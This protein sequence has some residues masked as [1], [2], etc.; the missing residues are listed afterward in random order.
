MAVSTQGGVAPLG[1]E[2]RFE[3]SNWPA[4]SGSRTRARADG[5][6]AATRGSAGAAPDSGP[7]PAWVRPPVDILASRAEQL[8]HRLPA[9]ELAKV[10]GVGSSV[11]LCLLAGWW[12]GQSA[13]VGAAL[14]LILGTPLALAF[15]L[16]SARARVLRLA[17]RR[18]ALWEELERFGL[19]GR[20][21]I[22]PRYREDD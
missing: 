20:L 12:L 22:P 14:L 19:S 16:W 2:E 21:R 8:M 10:W 9:G 6:C 15:T 5:G 1:L 18:P 17:R 4:R 7:A 3:D 11:P 13:P